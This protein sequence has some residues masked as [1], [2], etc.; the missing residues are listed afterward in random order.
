MAICRRKIWGLFF[1]ISLLCFLLCP[2]VW[3]AGTIS[4]SP[5]TYLT[6]PASATYWGIVT[7][8][9]QGPQVGDVIGVFDSSVVE[10]SGCIG[11]VAIDQ[12]MADAGS[13]SIATYGDDPSTQ[14][15]D[16][17]A[18]GDSL[19]FKLWRPSEGTMYILEP[20]SGVSAQSWPGDQQVVGNY[21]LTS[22]GVEPQGAP[23]A[24][25]TYSA[26]SGCAP[27]SVQFTDSSL[28]NPTAW[29]W[30]FG[31][32]S[33][34]S[35]EQNPSHT[36]SQPGTFTVSLTVTN[37]FGTSAP[38]TQTIQ[39]SAL[40]EADFSLNT[41]TGRGPL[42]VSFTDLSTNN[43]TS[44]EWDFGDG[45]S[46][47]VRNP[48][49]TY[50]QPGTYTVVLKA[51][52]ACGE[53]VKT[54]AGVVSV[55][56]S[57]SNLR[58]AF[59]L[60]AGALEDCAPLQV[61]F[62]DQSTGDPVS[63]EWSFGDGNISTARNPVHTFQRSGFY[64]VSLKVKNAQG[65]EHTLTQKKWIHVLIKPLADFRADKNV[66]CQG[67][68][69][70]FTDQSSGEPTMWRWNFGDGWISSKQNPEHKYEKPGLYMVRLIATNKCGYSLEQKRNFIEVRAPE[71]DFTTQQTGNCSQLTIQFTAKSPQGEIENCRWNF[72][73]SSQGGGSSNQPNPTYVYSRPGIYTVTLTADTPCGRAT[74]TKQIAVSG[75]PFASFAPSANPGTVNQTIKFTDQSTGGPTSW[76]WDFGDADH[77]TS[78]Q[79]NPTYRF[80]QPGEY[81]VSLKVSNHCGSHTAVRYI[82][83]V[84]AGENADP[85]FTP[86]SPI[87]SGQE[88]KFVTATPTGVSISDWQ[89]DFGDGTPGTGS[90]PSHI[91]PSPGT[92]HV[93]LTASGSLGKSY[94][95]VKSV[96][97]HE[98]PLISADITSGCAP[99]TVHFYDNA[100]ATDTSTTWHWAF[101]D[102]NQTT[103][104][105]P[106][107]TFTKEGNYVVNLSNEC[108]TAEPLTIEVKGH[109]EADFST[110]SLS[111]PAP[112]V[113]NFQNKSAG[114]TSLLWD[115]GDGE[116][117]RD[118][119]GSHIYNR[120]G[121]YKIRLIASNSDCEDEKSLWVDVYTLNSIQGRVLDADTKAPISGAQIRI[122]G[123]NQD[124]WSGAGGNYAIS[125]LRPG[126]YALA[127]S[128]GG[129]ESALIQQIRVVMGK[130][131]KQ[132]L[133]LKKAVG[134]IQGLVSGASGKGPIAGAKVVAMSMDGGSS[135]YLQQTI[136]DSEGKY[137]LYLAREGNYQL[138]VG[139]EGY[140]PVVDINQGAGYEIVSGS[141]QVVN[142][143]MNPSAWQPKLTISSRET[144]DAQS[145]S[146]QLE[147]F[148]YTDQT[149]SS[150]SI[151]SQDHVGS[152][153]A[154]EPTTDHENRPCYK[155]IYSGYAG[156]DI[157]TVAARIICT[158]AGQQAL[159]AT[160]PCAFPIQPN[161][162]GQGRCLKS[163]TRL[164]SRVEGGKIDG[165]GWIDLNGD[166]HEDIRDQ[167]FVDLPADFTSG[168]HTSESGS[169]LIASLSR[170]SDPTTSSLFAL[171]QINLM[172][173][174]GEPIAAEDF[175][176]REDNPII[177]H[178]QFDPTTFAGSMGDLI[179]SFQDQD[180][181]WKSS[182]KNVHL[183]GN[184]LVFTAT[185][186]G[187]FALFA[188]DSAPSNLLANQD[189]FDA[190]RLN[191]RWEDHAEHELG[192]EIWRCVDEDNP[193]SDARYTLLTELPPNVTQYIDPTCQIDRR[194]AYKVRAIMD[195]G[196][197]EYSD[198]TSL[199]V[200]ECESVPVPPA[201]LQISSVA[202]DQVV[203][204]WTDQSSCESGFDIWRRDGDSG[205]Y[206][207]IHTGAETSFTDRGV[208]PGCK[209]FYKVTAKS[210]KGDSKPSNEV[211]AT[212][213]RSRKKSSGGMCFISSLSS[214]WSALWQWIT[215]K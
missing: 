170:L 177:V 124:Y 64:D 27:L 176:I 140:L 138:V 161:I 149:V 42:E 69:V 70:K 172:D 190:R 47:T 78:T 89:W 144:Q 113:V 115:F 212:T 96:E 32:G 132:D 67:E 20:A 52:N 74:K 85:I 80:K 41:S 86:E 163:A 107:H 99:L 72:G 119:D 133:V 16:G 73:D 213:A 8:G 36:F 76:E 13:Y 142:I 54:K 160:L 150:L 122:L 18:I 101:G 93:T 105:N 215:G 62:Q 110:S 82:I 194:Y 11:A 193:M 147:I 71:V 141:N 6:T 128:A 183:I 199:A 55:Q 63:W 19:T 4:V 83:I 56:A 45:T 162:W 210:D 28:N 90:N 130:D 154:P 104:H 131:T 17:A 192:F 196:A 156:E 139:A 51:K 92:Y 209:Y 84:N 14:Q 75:V 68:T 203:L 204:S 201:N 100:P 60:A 155:V 116:L 143:T 174:Q 165:L 188:A 191:L 79:Q 102:G 24:R 103:G 175:P 145:G 151:D 31:D 118:P 23:Q 46:S 214:S 33:A 26:T 29:S 205:V 164:I 87:C 166:G 98:K 195:L 109:L 121:S 152:F 179:V 65:D 153:S 178:L 198:Y 44:W 12:A 171:Y 127:V 211:V 57:S 50:T 137:T 186:L 120:P 38:Y 3:A 40:P 159:S 66:I 125:Q 1:I 7:V 53:N 126:L 34:I 168:S 2:R 123:E 37:A 169:S 158:R 180:G 22:V 182:L 59:T 157:D 97:V 112:L 25:F 43:P 146:K 202:K 108:G 189:L 35:H 117:S 5:F 77:G 48:V 184:S 21:H 49:H 208:K 81:R 15:K 187:R 30:D 95:L 114:A 200:V 167:S 181:R 136:T 173:E 61:T 207:I 185:R 148:I 206:R 135:P 106:T 111:G 129:Y 88:V 58:A 9:G 197:T 91:F 134:T 10:N 39:T 94:S